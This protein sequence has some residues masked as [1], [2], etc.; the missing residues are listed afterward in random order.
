M[1]KKYLL[2]VSVWTN[3]KQVTYQRKRN[4]LKTMRNYRDQTKKLKRQY[5]M[6]PSDLS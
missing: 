6:G 4:A 5:N 3:A 1:N 2:P